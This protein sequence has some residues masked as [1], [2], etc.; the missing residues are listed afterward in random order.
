MA[1]VGAKDEIGPLPV[2]KARQAAAA[3]PSAGG[4]GST[5]SRRHTR[6]RPFSSLQLRCC[7]SACCCR[8]FAAADGCCW[9]E[10]GVPSACCHVLLL[11]SCSERLELV[12]SLGRIGGSG[13]RTLASAQEQVADLPKL[14]QHV[15]SVSSTGGRASSTACA[16]AH[17]AAIYSALCLKNSCSRRPAHQVGQHLDHLAIGAVHLELDL[18]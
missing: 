18:H 14:P 17:P 8:A 9:S 16:P 12:L 4:C 1:C 6:H 13:G 11:H 7:A 10:H 5:L 15:L 3:A 2:A